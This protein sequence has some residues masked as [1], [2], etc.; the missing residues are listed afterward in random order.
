MYPKMAGVWREIRHPSISLS[1]K[2]VEIV[3]QSVLQACKCSVLA[4]N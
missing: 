1:S 2:Q 4:I 3:F